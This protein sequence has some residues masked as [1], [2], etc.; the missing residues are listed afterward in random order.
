M[1]TE[2]INEK[3]ADN[4][5]G[6]NQSLNTL[7]KVLLYTFVAIM[8]LFALMVL[9]KIMEFLFVGAV[10]LIGWIGVLPRRWR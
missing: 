1:N 10:L 8:G 9:Y 7:A 2:N 6:K 5:M 4:A 3:R